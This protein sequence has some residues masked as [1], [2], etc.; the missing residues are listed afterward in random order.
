MATTVVKVVIAIVVALS[1]T[2]M[3]TVASVVAFDKSTTITVLYESTTIAMFY[4]S[5]TITALCEPRSSRSGAAT[6]SALRATAATAGHCSRMSTAA[7]ATGAHAAAVAATTVPA[8]A[9][10]V[11]TTT[12]PATLITYKRDYPLIGRLGGRGPG[13][14]LCRTPYD[15]CY[16]EAARKGSRRKKFRTHRNGLLWEMDLFTQPQKAATSCFA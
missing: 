5:A 4:K 15:R 14:G 16:C 2:A 7:T 13:H 8:T 11:A 12:A 10:A 1:K 9:A 6:H 3:I